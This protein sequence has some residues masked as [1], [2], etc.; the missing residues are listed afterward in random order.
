MEKILEK[1]SSQN[2]VFTVCES[3]G[4]LILAC[5][6][7]NCCTTVKINKQPKT[8]KVCPYDE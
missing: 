3:K 5:Y 7:K 6:D 8:K 1:K 4:S 2:Q